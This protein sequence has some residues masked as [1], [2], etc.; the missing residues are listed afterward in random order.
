MIE[1][2]EA[3]GAQWELPTLP[4]APKGGNEGRLGGS[5]AA[6]CGFGGRSQ[7]IEQ[8]VE[9]LKKKVKQGKEHREEPRMSAWAQGVGDSNGVLPGVFSE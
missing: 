3:P 6:L 7:K 9:V 1:K 5:Y 2:L 4:P 8:A